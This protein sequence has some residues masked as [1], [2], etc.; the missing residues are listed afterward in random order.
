MGIFDYYNK[1][2]KNGM[3]TTRTDF[4]DMVG[5]EGIQCTAPKKADTK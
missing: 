1:W 2:G 3:K 5:L 4:I